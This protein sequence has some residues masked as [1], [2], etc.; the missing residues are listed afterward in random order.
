MNSPFTISPV[1]R[2][3]LIVTGCVGFSSLMFLKVSTT[4]TSWL[5]LAGIV[6]FLLG[7]LGD[8]LI[9]AI[10]GT[11]SRITDQAEP[12]ISAVLPSASQK[13][14]PSISEQIFNKVA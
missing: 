6:P 4:L 12:P 7:L 5:A 3:I 8:N 11:K 1:L 14:S 13:S 9:L 10:F 2:S